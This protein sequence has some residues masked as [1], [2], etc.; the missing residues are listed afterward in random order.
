[1]RNPIVTV[2]SEQIRFEGFS[3]C[4]GVYAKL[5]IIDDGVAKCTCQWYSKYQGERGE[6][7]HVLAVK[8]MLTI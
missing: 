4:A 2:G 3:Q 8:S 7:K 6:C 1:M 5:V